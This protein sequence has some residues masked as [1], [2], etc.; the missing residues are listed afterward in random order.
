MSL[1]RVKRL[2]QAKPKIWHVL[3]TRLSPFKKISETIHQE[4]IHQ[5]TIHQE[6]FR[7]KPNKPTWD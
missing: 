5:E 7:S 1:K 4:I 2:H 3:N 6:M